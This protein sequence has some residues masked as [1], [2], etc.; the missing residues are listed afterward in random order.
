[1]KRKISILFISVATF[2]LLVLMTIPHHHHENGVACIVIEVCE[3]DNEIN[4]EHTHHNDVPDK[5]NSS[6]CLIE[7]E[8]TIPHPNDDIKYKISYRKDNIHNNFQLFSAYFLVAGFINCDT[9]YLLPK[10]EYGEHFSF[11][12]SAEANQYHGLRAPPSIFT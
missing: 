3:H 4:D 9:E 8:F 12:K 5:G 11:Y 10:N 2:I 7:A 6:N 1:M